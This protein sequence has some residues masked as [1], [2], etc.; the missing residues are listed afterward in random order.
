MI[1]TVTDEMV[2]ENPC[3]TRNSDMIAALTSIGLD[4]IDNISI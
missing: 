1:G 2:W 3:K 4:I